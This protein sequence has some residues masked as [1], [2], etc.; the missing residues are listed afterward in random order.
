MILTYTATRNI[1]EEPIRII[2]ED[3]IDLA[4]DCA[5]D[6][7]GN[8]FPASVDT[9]GSVIVILTLEKGKT[10]ELELCHDG[11]TYD[12][13]LAHSEES[14]SVDVNIAGKLFTRYVYDDEFAKPFL[15]PVLASDG[16]TSFT[17]LDF[18]TTEHPHQRS[19]IGAIGDVNGID[20][21]NEFGNYGY[22]RQ[23]AIKNCMS[24][25]AFGRV[26][27]EICWQSREGEP[28]LN[29]ERTFTFYNQQGDVKYVDIE[30]KFIADYCD[31][32]VGKTKEA[33]PLG[34]RVN[35]ELRADRGG[36]FTNSYGGI[37]EE[38]CWGK[39]AHFCD[40]FGN[41]NG[42]LYGIAVFDNEQNERFP[43]AWHI[44]NYGLFAANNLYFKGGYELKKGQSVIYRYRIC[45][46]EGTKPDVY[47]KYNCYLA[48]TKEG[49]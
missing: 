6:A 47:G 4:F 23:K 21:W 1:T 30:M 44:R 40:Y 2:C 38:E 14:R 5:K 15:G 18:E 37:N 41:I 39:S 25:S 45:F 9:D 46:Y 3:A 35:E 34:V 33:G 7:S 49:E 11:D 20:F 42:K 28:V 43:T 31:V 29:E 32:T 8:K 10:V 17:R 27:A 24:G 36:S 16:L 48:F 12:V 19:I 13:V 26:S 22:E